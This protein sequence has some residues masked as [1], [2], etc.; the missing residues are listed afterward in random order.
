MTGTNAMK[1]PVKG[2]V[3]AS[4]WSILLDSTLV[5]T[6]K[7]YKVKVQ[8]DLVVPES[9]NLWLTTDAKTTIQEWPHLKGKRAVSDIKNVMQAT[10]KE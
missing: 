2:R 9:G 10:I 5:A 7:H 3:M 6:L 4:L 8:L 1:P